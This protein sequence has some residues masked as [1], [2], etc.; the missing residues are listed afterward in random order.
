MFLKL[1]STV[2]ISEVNKNY[3]EQYN[4]YENNIYQIIKYVSDNHQKS[5]NKIP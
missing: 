5:I 4:K 1:I 3:F 2:D